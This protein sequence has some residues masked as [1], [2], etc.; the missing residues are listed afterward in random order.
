MAGRTAKSGKV[1]IVFGGL[2]D[3]QSMTFQTA[4]GDQIGTAGSDSL[5]D[6][7]ANRSNQFVGGDGND[8]V[9]GN[10]GADVLYGGRGNDTFVLNA[11]NLAQ[12]ARR[13]GNASQD[14]ARVSGGT[15]IDKLQFDGAG[16][17]I[18]LSAVQRS[19]LD[20]VEKI[21]I[22]GSGNNTLRLGL[23]DVLNFGDNNIWNAGN[24]NGASGEALSATEARRQLRVEGNAGDQ[25]RLTGIADWARASNDMVDGNTYAVWN[26]SSIK[27]QLLIDTRVV[28]A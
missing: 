20:G 4:N 15:G 28:V 21:D 9:T 16:L 6:T 8:T 7:T 5:G 18:D 14:I 25:V 13:T 27:A 23:M 26:H 11:D 1:F 12:L 2:S 17:D 22:T 24:T 19:A 3:L 10:G